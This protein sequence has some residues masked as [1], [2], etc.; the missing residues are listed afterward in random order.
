MGKIIKNKLRL[1]CEKE[2]LVEIEKDGL[3]LARRKGREVFND[4]KSCINSLYELNLIN[5]H[6]KFISL[7]IQKILRLY[8]PYKVLSLIYF[9]LRKNIN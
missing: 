3:F 5:K 6:Q 7:I 1:S 2:I 8:T 4:I 9:I